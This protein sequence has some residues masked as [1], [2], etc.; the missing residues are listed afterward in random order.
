LAIIHFLQSLK[1]IAFK[2]KNYADQETNS[3][4]LFAPWREF[5][6]LEVYSKVQMLKSQSK[7]AAP[8][9]INLDRNDTSQ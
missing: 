9:A 7:P 4:V 6:F 3:C 2:K 8:A 5:L 1:D